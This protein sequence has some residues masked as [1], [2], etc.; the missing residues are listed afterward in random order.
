MI[1]SEILAK[2]F[3]IILI[4]RAIASGGYF[5]DLNL[6]K[7]D[8]VPCQTGSLSANM[9]VTLKAQFQF[10]NPTLLITNYCL[11]SETLFAFDAKRESAYSYREALARASR[12][13]RHYELF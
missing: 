7:G 1:V 11:L 6:T 10:K 9:G 2:V 4:E 13:E 8:R 3:E 12:R 5:T